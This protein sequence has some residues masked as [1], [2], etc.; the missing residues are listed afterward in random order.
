MTRGFLY[1]GSSQVLV[2]LWTVDDE[3]TTALMSEL[4]RG[5]L[6]RGEASAGALRSAQRWMRQHERW[7]APC[8]WG[9]FVLQGDG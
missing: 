9:A 4:Y 5:L 8:F 7:S 2:S 1:A 3:A 6:L